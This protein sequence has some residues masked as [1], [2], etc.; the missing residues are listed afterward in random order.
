MYSPE[1]VIAAEEATVTREALV[2]QRAPALGALHAMYMPHAVENVEQKPIENWSLATGTRQ[3]HCICVTLVTPT[4]ITLRFDRYDD[5]RTRPRCDW[6]D[7]L[8]I[9]EWQHLRRRTAKENV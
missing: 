3:Q 2:G 6:L 4:T 7:P 5:G 8:A 1:E 9:V